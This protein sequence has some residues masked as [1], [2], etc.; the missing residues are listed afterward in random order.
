V[1]NDNADTPITAADIYHADNVGDK[2]NN[3]TPPPTSVADAA[4][5]RINSNI[6][7]RDSSTDVYNTTV[8]VLPRSSLPSIDDVDADADAALLSLSLLSPVIVATERLRRLVD[9]EGCRVAIANA[10]IWERPATTFQP[11]ERMDTRAAVA[12]RNIFK[13]QCCVSEIQSNKKW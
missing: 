3:A 9:K 8:P 2:A 11:R 13:P 7:L 10:S 1:Y 12:D 6:R 4:P 5:R